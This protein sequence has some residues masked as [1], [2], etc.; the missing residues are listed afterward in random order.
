M[1]VVNAILPKMG[2]IRKSLLGVVF[3]MAQ[4]AGLGL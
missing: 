3:G 4:Y 1:L 2:I